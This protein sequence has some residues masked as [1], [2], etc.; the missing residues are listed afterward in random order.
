M[1]ECFFLL[2]E[3]VRRLCKSALRAVHSPANNGIT[4][5]KRSHFVLLLL[6]VAIV[7]LLLV[8]CA[9]RICIEI[10]YCR[11]LFQLKY[12]NTNFN[13]VYFYIYLFIF[14]SVIFKLI[15]CCLIS[16]YNLSDKH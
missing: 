15:Y 1:R 2:A 12:V 8:V 6:L 16:F 11:S 10:F 7:F 9:Y 14:Y 4:G 3:P 5:S 13:F